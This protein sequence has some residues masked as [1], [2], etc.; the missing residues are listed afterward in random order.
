MEMMLTRHF[1][2]G[3]VQSLGE[4]TN[5][6]ALGIFSIKWILKPWK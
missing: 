2:Y 6:R 1:I 5:L 4:K 3:S